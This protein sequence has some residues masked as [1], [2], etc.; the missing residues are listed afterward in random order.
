VEIFATAASVVTRT[1]YAEVTGI[2]HG[3]LGR[4]TDGVAELR[5]ARTGVRHLLGRAQR[6]RAGQP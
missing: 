1:H 5:A 2:K 4:W 3:K 6:P